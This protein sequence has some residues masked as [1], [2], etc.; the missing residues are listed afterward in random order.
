M[1]ICKYLNYFV[2]PLRLSNVDQRRI[3]FM[4]SAAV[5]P[6]RQKKFESASAWTFL[7]CGGDIIVSE[8]NLW[9]FVCF[10]LLIFS[11]LR[12]SK[13]LKWQN[14]YYL[15]AFHLGSGLR[16]IRGTFHFW[17]LRRSEKDHMFFYVFLRPWLILCG[18]KRH[19]RLPLWK[20]HY[21]S[22]TV[23]FKFLT[24]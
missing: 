16:R 4:A 15:E 19:D 5:S 14:K 6:A 7:F 2:R 21:V 20:H 11:W 3:S 23:H 17:P 24:H 22:I 1:I 10:R 9:S 8:W 18:Q 13:W 12:L